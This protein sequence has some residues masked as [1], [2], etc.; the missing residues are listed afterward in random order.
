MDSADVN[1]FSPYQMG[2]F[3]LNNRIVMAPLTR[4][5]AGPGNVP[6]TMAESREIQLRLFRRRLDEKIKASKSSIY[7]RSKARGS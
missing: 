7:R 1:L 5:R 2:P 3:R 4:S 6:S